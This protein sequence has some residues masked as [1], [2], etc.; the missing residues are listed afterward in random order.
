MGAKGILVQLF[1]LKD[2]KVSD[3]GIITQ[4]FVNGETDGGRP[5]S[6]R[7]DEMYQPKGEIVQLSNQVTKWLE[8]NEVD[9]KVGD[10]V[11]IQ[12]GSKHRNN[13]F[14]ENPETGTE[15]FTGLVKLHPN[16]I[17]AKLIK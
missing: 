16:N 5:V 17:E 10:T 8:E 7:S 12:P 13:W 14:I 11:L 3:A 4:A 6:R 9:L 2:E 1:E 15:E